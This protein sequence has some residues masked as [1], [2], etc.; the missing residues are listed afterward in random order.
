MRLGILYIYN[1]TGVIGI[2]IKSLDFQSSFHSH[3]SGT[4]NYGKLKI[5]TPN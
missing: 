3:P 2:N 5:A 4:F 1:G